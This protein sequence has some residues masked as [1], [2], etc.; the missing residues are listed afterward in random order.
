MLS[1]SVAGSGVLESPVTAPESVPEA[2]ASSPEASA[3]EPLDG[4]P[5][6]SP[7]PSDAAASASPEAPAS[8]PATPEAIDPFAGGTPFT[9][10]VD[11]TEISPQGAKVVGDHVVIPRQAWEQEVRGKW[12]GN[13]D[14]WRQREGQW[15]HRLRETES[16]IA[17]RQEELDASLAVMR[18]FFKNPETA[19]ALLQDWERQGPLLQARA[20]TQRYKAQAERY[21]REQQEA[22]ERRQQAEF[23]PQVIQAMGDFVGQTL[24][25]AGVKWE[26]DKAAEQQWGGFIRELVEDYGVRAMLRTDP[27][28][29]AV[30]LDRE[31][32]GRLVQRELGRSKAQ[33]STVKAAEKV[34][35]QNAAAVAPPKPTAPVPTKPVAK[36]TTTSKSTGEPDFR[37][38]PEAW[39]K[40]FRKI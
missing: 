36:A 6:P 5:A 40:W 38:D 12:L 39:E 35:Q 20:E 22:A 3:T 19:R 31:K 4:P 18:E 29:G 1:D 27:L 26:G 24:T 17:G 23:A 34:V 10:R 33:Q 11:G 7:T 21:D 14:A 25:E 2:P 13:R 16:R 32:L 37:T 30:D 9:F 15:E 8:A 28:T